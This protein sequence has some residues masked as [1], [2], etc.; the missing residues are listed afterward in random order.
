MIHSSAEAELRRSWRMVG[1]ATLTIV[2]S[3]RSMH[4]AASTRPRIS[5]LRG[6]LVYV[7]GGGDGV[8]AG[9][10]IALSRTLFGTLFVERTVLYTAGMDASTP[11]HGSPLPTPP[12]APRRRESP[13]RRTAL[14]V[15]GIVAAAIEVLD[16]TGVS[17]LSMRAVAQQLDT[18]AASLY[19]HVSGKEELLELVFDEL[20]GRVPLPEPDPR[21]WREQMH[22][23]A[24]NLRQILIS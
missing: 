9:V 5:H 15:E 18:G 14:T 16:E 17:G 3:R 20:I 23:M 4:S 11:D 8:V 22:E 12:R 21:R 2:P 13:P 24:S 1:A 7:V 10:I 19:A 6:W